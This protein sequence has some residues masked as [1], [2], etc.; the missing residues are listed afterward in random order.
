MKLTPPSGGSWSDYDHVYVGLD[1]SAGTGLVDIVDDDTHNL[2]AKVADTEQKFIVEA[3]RGLLT[4][5][6]EYDLS[7]LTL[8]ES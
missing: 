6:Q 2:V 3:H 8:N 7:G 4:V 5:R 1:P